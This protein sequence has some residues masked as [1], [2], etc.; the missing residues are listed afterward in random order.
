MQTV[1]LLDVHRGPAK[2]AQPILKASLDDLL[3]QLECGETER[4]TF[5]NAIRLF[6][7]EV[8]GD[9]DRRTFVVQLAD[10]A[11]SFYSLSAPP[12]VSARLQSKLEEL[13]LFLDTNFLFGILG[14]HVNPFDSVSE[15][16]IAVVSRE[17]LP[18]KLRYHE[19]TLDEMH[20]TI[21]GITS[22][23]KGRYWPQAVSRA[24]IRSPYIS[25]IE[26]RF[27][28]MNANQ[29]VDPAVFFEP[30]DHP[31]V[32]LKDKG[33]QIYRSSSRRLEERADL[34]GQYKEFLERRHREKPYE[35]IDHDMTVLDCVRHLRSTAA[36]SLDAKG[37]IVTCDTLLTRFDWQELRTN[38]ELACTVLPNHFLQLLRP[39]I[40]ASAEFD[41][42][43]AE[44]FAIAEFRTISKSNEATLKLLTMLATY[45]DIREETVQSLLANELLIDKLKGSK[46][47]AEFK[48][49]VDAAIAA[50]NAQLLEELIAAQDQAA[51]EK[52]ESESVRADLETQRDGL[53][54]NNTDLRNKLGTLEDE[55]AKTNT[56]SN[57]EIAVLKTNVTTKDAEMSQLER[58]LSQAT[59]TLSIGA[60]AICA[61][62]LALIGEFAIRRLNWEWLLQHPNSYSLRASAYIAVLVFFLGLFRPKWRKFC[63]YGSAGF[64]GVICDLAEFDRGAAREQVIGLSATRHPVANSVANLLLR[65][66]PNDTEWEKA[67]RVEH[68]DRR[69]RITEFLIGSSLSSIARLGLRSSRGSCFL[70]RDSL[71]FLPRARYSLTVSL[72]KQAGI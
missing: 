41:K 6:L 3:D 50:E 49:L 38:D 9:S 68:K 18:F 51:R 28:E 15:E 21:V 64:F 43:F 72:P 42:S 40:T 4:K 53:L 70:T 1:S 67:R 62:V 63:W 33:I 66:I 27:H 61:V 69:S 25:G 58:Q 13:T 12:E 46:N 10:G 45:E 55:L 30:Y 22:T 11:F 26:K 2:D 37:L 47:D 39:F 36:S 32:L 14:L 31:D 5:E 23:L 71:L 24:A 54:E 20:R 44:S 65:A 17:K 57:T 34:I 16:L 59:G 48:Q 8:G 19:A 56:Q 52:T 7:S 29:T 35:A 60:A